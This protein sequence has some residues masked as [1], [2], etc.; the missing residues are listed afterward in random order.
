MNTREIIKSWKWRIVKAGYRSGEFAALLGIHASL[1]SNYLNEK[2]NPSLGKFDLI[3]Q[4]L[5]ELGV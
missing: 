2:Q 5:R 3:E 4:K 1:M